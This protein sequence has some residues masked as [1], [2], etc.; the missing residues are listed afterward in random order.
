MNGILTE[1]I[2]KNKE[3][4][5]KMKEKNNKSLATI[6]KKIATSVATYVAVPAFLL[7]IAMLAPQKPPK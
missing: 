4:Y 2:Y 6:T 3:G 7:L 1:Y 5:A